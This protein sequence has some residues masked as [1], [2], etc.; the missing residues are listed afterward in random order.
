MCQL[1]IQNK[2]FYRQQDFSVFFPVFK[3]D[4]QSSL[5]VKLAVRK[6]ICWKMFSE[7]LKYTELY[8]KHDN[9]KTC[10]CMRV[11]KISIWDWI[12]G[13][14]GV[15]NLFSFYKYWLNFNFRLDIQKKTTFFENKWKYNLEIVLIN[16]NLKSIVFWLS[17]IS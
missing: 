17:S 6:T 5:S 12:T 14:T 7:K 2:Y 9:L 11:K 4:F 1:S 13:F 8:L 16:T 15:K 3:T 10:Q